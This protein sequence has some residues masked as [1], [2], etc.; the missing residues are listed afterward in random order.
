MTSNIYI[1]DGHILD[2]IPEK[3]PTLRDVTQTPEFKAL[4]YDNSIPVDENGNQISFINKGKTRKGNVQYKRHEEARTAKYAMICGLRRDWENEKAGNRRQDKKIRSVLAEKYRICEVSVKKYLKMTDLE[5]ERLLQITEYKKRRTPVNDYLNMIY[6][7][8]RD[9]IQPHVIYQ[10]VL[11]KGYTGSTSS[12]EQHICAIGSN[13][14]LM[15]IGRYACFTM[16]L[17]KGTVEIRRNEILKFMTIKDRTRMENSEVT[18]YYDLLKEKYPVIEAC[19]HLWNDFHQTLM[20]EDPK[21]LDD[22]IENQERL[23]NNSD[24]STLL[25]E[26]NGFVQG[27]KKDIAPIKNAIS[28]S[29]NSGFVE[30]GNCRYKSTKRLMFGRAGQK[31]L[32]YKTY[33]ISII[34]HQHKNPKDLLLEWLNCPDR[35]IWPKRKRDV[36]TN[37]S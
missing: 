27:L 19:E 37:I 25:R 31:H 2:K 10:Y 32:F 22:F 17:P 11:S 33:A 29:L 9:G 23:Y 14:H 12:L 28:F 35:K 24:F 26:T 4:D 36:S 8:L 21:R 6:K 1:Q 7:M 30:G 13:N 34:M 5:V 16:E 18:Q 15:Q 3:V 20:G